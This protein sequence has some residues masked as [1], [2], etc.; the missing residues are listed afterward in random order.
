MVDIP[1][2]AELMAQDEDLPN[3]SKDGKK[4]SL[5]I[6]LLAETCQV[7]GKTSIYNGIV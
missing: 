2:S 7:R 3:I 5:Y 4:T 6:K 1:K